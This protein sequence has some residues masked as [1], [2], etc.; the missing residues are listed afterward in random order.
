MFLFAAACAVV[1]LSHL[2]GEGLTMARPTLFTHRKYLRLIHDLG[3]P[4]PLV[5]GCLELMWNA[6]YQTGDP[7]LGDETDV[8][9]AA[10]WPGGKGIFCAALHK[11]GFLDRLED[12]RFQVHDLLDHAPEYVASRARREEERRKEKVCANPECKQVFHSSEAH[13]RYCSDACKQEGY[14]LRKNERVTEG[15]YAAPSQDAAPTPIKQGV[16]TECDEGLRNSY[17]PVTSCYAPP[18]PAPAPAPKEEE[19]PS[20]VCSELAKTPASEPSAVA[21]IFP[22]KGKGP[23]TWDLCSDRLQEYRETFPDLDVL[24]ELKKALLWCR[25]NPAKQ[26]T[27]RGMAA[28]LTRWLSKAQNSGTGGRSGATPQQSTEST[29]DRH[30]RIQ[31]EMQARKQ[32][33]PALAGDAIRERLRQ[34]RLIPATS[35]DNI[36]PGGEE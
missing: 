6:A 24:G 29:A 32:E 18:A 4:E 17:E 27:A 13:A 8:E 2:E 20:D 30:K 21:L 33:G 31:A 26:K 11:Q 23:K 16:V 15:C 19:H 10:K 34:A 9:L 14:R 35:T 25:D 28:F 7:L 3:E 5:L 1:R 36:K 12:G 22:T